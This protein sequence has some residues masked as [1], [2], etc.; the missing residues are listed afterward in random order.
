MILKEIDT[1]GD[2]YE[3][4]EDVEGRN[5]QVVFVAVRFV[6]HSRPGRY[7]VAEADRG[8]RGEAKVESVEATPILER[9]EYEH[10]SD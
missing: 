8:Q 3:A 9:A 1:H 10:A 6:E 4:D 5:V 7:E 2:E